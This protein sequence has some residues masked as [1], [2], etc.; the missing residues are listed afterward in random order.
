MLV[1][2]DPADGANQAY[3][4]GLR[5]GRDTS[6]FL[7]RIAVVGLRFFGKVRAC[8]SNSPRLSCQKRIMS[9]DVTKTNIHSCQL[10]PVLDV[11]VLGKVKHSYDVGLLYL[12]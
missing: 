7:G 12:C 3:A 8:R 2:L 5:E 10:F 1:P 11:A 6:E 9:N 4:K